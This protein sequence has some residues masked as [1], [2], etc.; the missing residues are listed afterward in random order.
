MASL[1]TYTLIQGG[2][3]PEA[4][5]WLLTSSK[6]PKSTCTISSNKK[7]DSYRTY[8]VPI[9]INA[10]HQ[11]RISEIFNKIQ[12]L[13]KCHSNDRVRTTR[14]A[15]DCQ[16]SV[17]C[18]YTDTNIT[19]TSNVRPIIAKFFNGCADEIYVC[20]CIISF[21]GILWSNY[22]HF[23]QFQ[24]LPEGNSIC[25]FRAKTLSPFHWV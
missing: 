1:K 16:Y 18:F 3:K 23:T 4:T 7:F 17:V 10:E 15:A 20:T 25:C 22:E 6:K 8:G 11:T 19:F 24:R 12:I 14:F 13:Q 5:F 2:T 9:N 21:I